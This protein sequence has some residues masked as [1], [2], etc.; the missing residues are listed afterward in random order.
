VLD[1]PAPPPRMPTQTNAWL[2]A[3]DDVYADRYLTT[4]LGA[5]SSPGSCA[6]LARP[7]AGA[8]RV[9]LASQSELFEP[10]DLVWEDERSLRELIH[11]LVALRLPLRMS[12]VPAASPTVRA[13]LSIAGGHGVVR[14]MAVAGWPGLDLDVDESADPESRLNSGRRSDLRRMRRRADALGA[15]TFEF[16]T[17]LADDVPALLSAAYAV[18]AASW[19]GRTGTALAMDSRRGRFY[20]RYAAAAARDGELRVCFMRID[21]APAAMQI[22]ACVDHRLWLL[23]IGFDERFAAC[24]PGQL[25]ML[26]SI[27]A[28]A[29]EGLAG[30]ELLGYPEP[31]TAM[32]APQLRDCVALRYYP[33]AGRAVPALVEDALAL[34]RRAS[35]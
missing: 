13:L 35:R 5:G 3:F 34:L 15:V 22:A 27:R 26:E 6:P 12:R 30:Y 10:M 16:H 17:P 11:R 19:K 20:R 2:E 24:S 7:L 23:K 33:L 28:A 1:L 21:D 18:E 8:L 9:E 29:G 25:L 14:T 32:W 31:W 4:K